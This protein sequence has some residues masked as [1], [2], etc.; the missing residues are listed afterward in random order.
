MITIEGSK[1]QLNLIRKTKTTKEK[2]KWATKII[3]YEKNLPL[4]FVL[5]NKKQSISICVLDQEQYLTVKFQYLN[6]TSSWDIEINCSQY[7]I[8]RILNRYIKN[9]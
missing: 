2:D 7:I 4:T 5:L 1:L 3:D 9:W 8:S 6:K